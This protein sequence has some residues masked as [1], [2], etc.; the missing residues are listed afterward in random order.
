MLKKDITFTD[1]NGDEVTETYY[2]NLSRA[3]LVE[4]EV[5]YS[6]G[7]EAAITRII[8]TRDVRNLI[9]EFKKIILLSYGVRSEDG[10]KF[11]K[12]QEL[13]DDFT[14]TAAY[15]ALFMEL[16]TDADAAAVFMNGIIPKGLDAKDV[17]SPVLNPEPTT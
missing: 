6:G 3:E 4:L 12:N 5:S 10:K 1:Y 14:Q 8:E 17:N 13:R 2:F 7:I 16:A 11:I 15:D 9:K